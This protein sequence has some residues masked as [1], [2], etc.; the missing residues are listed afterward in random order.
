MINIE[1]YCEYLYNSLYIPIYI[2]DNK[3]LVVSYPEQE[4]TTLPPS[5]YLSNLWAANNSISYTMTSFYSHYGCIKV[6]NSTTYIVIGPVN[7]LYYTKDTLT[8][9][10]KE[11]SVEES[12]LETF[13]DFFTSIPAVNIQAFMNTL[14]FINF[15]LN[16]TELTRSDI[17]GYMNYSH[18]TDINR[19]YSENSYI[20]KEEGINFNSHEMSNKLMRYIETGNVPALQKLLTHSAFTFTGK[21][22]NAKLRH[23][24]NLFIS[25]INMAFNAAMKGGLSPSIAYQLSEVYIQQAERLT[26]PDAVAALIEQSMTDFAKRVA[27]S[28]IPANADNTLRQV[29]Q[30]VRSNI[31]Q[32]ITVADVS[33]HVGFS[34]PHLSQ[35][36][37]KETG[38]ELS[39]F[40]RKCKL[41]EAKDLLAYSNKSISEISSYLCF[42][43]QSHF[44]KAF[45]NQFGVTPQ[46]YR[47]SI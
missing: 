30:Y 31:N 38:I 33:K 27:D 11:F 12:E 4:K 25:T 24:K 32:N 42:S 14:L 47:K 39:G 3:T 9:M 20:A 46:A 13:F 22:A 16:N 6:E 21:L 5:Y 34:R 28:I 19:K 10:S 2:Y 29:I 41:E 23:L 17:A 26:D 36:F 40:I 44:Q 15:T 43:S 37:K 7:N 1:K 8:V 18:N 45:K 35:K